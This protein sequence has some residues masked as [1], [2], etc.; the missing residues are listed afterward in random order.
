MKP[1]LLKFTSDLF[2]N[3]NLEKVLFIACQHI[4][5]STFDMFEGY[6]KRGLK[7]ENT[8]LI[9]KCYSTNEEIYNKFLEVGVNISPSSK[10]F[11]S[12]V[13]FD[14]QFSGYIQEF[15]KIVQTSVDFNDFEKILILDD[16]AQLLLY[17]NDFIQETNK[18]VGIEQTSSG[19]EKLKSCSLKFPVINVA[20]SKA[21]LEVE[22]PFI[23]DLV[24]EKLQA[25]LGESNLQNPK[26][27]IV[28]QG[29]IGMSV[30]NLLKDTYEVNGCDFLSNKCDFGGNYKDQLHQ[31]D[32]IIGATGQTIIFEGDFGKLKNGV[33]LMSVSSSDREF[34]AVYFR[35]QVEQ[36]A[37]CHRDYEVNGIRLLN[38]GFPINFTGEKYSLPKERAQFTRALLSAGVYQAML[39]PEIGLVELDE[40]IQTSI[41]NE[42]RNLAQ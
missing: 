22:S 40:Q 9:G 19:Y 1:S 21:K 20:R 37:D 4:H 33:V 6:F 8:F 28:G 29:Y 5:A 31:F 17:A 15:F 12:H 3:V 42:F 10:A 11:D 24:A 26:I 32:M 23:A 27:L 13:S 35:R 38:A 36:N 7:P 14:E 41:T 30:L 2:P 16:G 39:K 25:Y 34:S 18:V